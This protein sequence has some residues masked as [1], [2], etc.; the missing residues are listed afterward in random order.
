[1]TRHTVTKKGLVMPKLMMAR[2]ASAVMVAVCAMLAAPATAA[3]IE[4]DTEAWADYTEA[5]GTGFAW[6]VIRAVYK[7]AGVD[8]EINAV[9]YA[10]AV[11]NV[12]SGKADAWVGSYADEVE[13][14]VYPEWHYDADKVSALYYKD[15]AG[16]WSGVSDLEGA[17][18]AWVLGYKMDAYIDVPMDAQTLQERESAAR[19]LKHGRVDYFLDAA[20]EIT[21]LMENLPEGVSADE[22]GRKHVTNLPLYL[23]FAPTE[24]GRKFAE[25]WDERFPKLLKNGTLAEIYDKHGMTVWPFD[26]A[27]DSGGV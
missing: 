8:L 6:D 21:T 9:P 20:Y 16:S 2:P 27:R 1:M 15:R 12:T 10:R 22:F 23:G 24:Q 13:D 26:V 18:V 17:R 11:N 3:T 19:M 5:D 4:I 7:P 25:I 14:A